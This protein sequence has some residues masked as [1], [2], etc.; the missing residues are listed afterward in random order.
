MN[1]R[2]LITAG[3]ATVLS[4]RM[5]AP[6]EAQSNPVIR[7]G[8]SVNDSGLG[9]VYAYETG[10][11]QKAGLNVETAAAAKRLGHRRGNHWGKR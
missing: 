8:Y 11:F 9:P 4:S 5:A 7:I 2:S 1:R 10:L 6:S 3:T